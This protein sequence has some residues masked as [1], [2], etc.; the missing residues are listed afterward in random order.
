M[1]A[2]APKFTGN[3][4]APGVQRG[5]T[6][7]EILVVMAVSVLLLGLLFGPMVSSFNLVHRGE[8]I[9]QSQETA[10]RVMEQVT[11]EVAD[12]VSVAVYPGDSLPVR[13]RASGENHEAAHPGYIDALDHLG[14]G[15]MGS[16]QQLPMYG[17]LLDFVPADDTLGLHGGNLKQPL[18]PQVDE[19][20]HPVV[21]RY[22]V[23]LRRPAPDPAIKDSP[24]WLNPNEKP[25]I[26]GL[27][28]DN[29]YLLYRA[30]FDPMDPKFSNW[31]VPDP[32]NSGRYIINPDFFYDQNTVPGTVA[33]EDQGKT[34]AQVWREAS[35]SLVPVSDLDLVRLEYAA[36]APDNAPAQRAV[37]SVVF[38]PARIEAEVASPSDTLRGA[39]ITYRTQHGQ[40]AGLQ[41]D[42]TVASGAL[43]P[44]LLK[45]SLPQITVFQTDASM[46]G[47]V[48]T[49]Y[50]STEPSSAA[51]RLLTWDSRAG[52][53]GFALQAPPLDFQMGKNA[54]VSRNGWLLQPITP[55][56][57]T[58]PT[59]LTSDGKR[60][61]I[62]H[63]VPGTETV[64]VNGTLYRRS[65]IINLDGSAEGEVM[66]DTPDASTLGLSVIPTD[67]PRQLPA[68]FTYVLDLRSGDIIVGYPYPGP[69]NPLQPVPI[70]ENAAVSIRFQ[71]Q[72]NHPGDIVRVSYL[73][74][75]L[76]TFNLGIRMYDR[77]TGKPQLV[78][79]SN[80]IRLRNAGR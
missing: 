4:R 8:Q 49:V 60:I 29:T 14:N 69:A 23:G 53:I 22:F 80:R 43:N 16:A 67:Y 58:L 24:R 41:N 38:A 36:D 78:S 57:G 54:A 7:I 9:A 13:F 3:R 71:Y 66:M 77:A 42:G 17:A 47:G 70:P 18:A 48:R 26:S 5:F 27:G 40:W 59:E 15:R 44:T 76:L 1:N 12:A 2:V 34:F 6:L 73:T 65:G 20:G 68:P 61:P 10:R 52:T 32:A 19:N 21:V 62:A 75:S 25:S 11:R 45:N 79:L 28:Q 46:A 39:P 56:L 74:R 33:S 64:A 50:D 72:T 31:A 37:S 55:A 63:I 35:V 30:E 51:Q